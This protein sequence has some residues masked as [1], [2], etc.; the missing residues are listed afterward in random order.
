MQGLRCIYRIVA[1][2]D[3][4]HGVFGKEGRNMLSAQIETQTVKVWGMSLSE[5]GAQILQIVAFL[6]TYAV[7][8]CLYNLC[9]VIICSVSR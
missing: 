2:L 9:I 1:L 4:K 3:E 5:C 8:V 6:F 7:T